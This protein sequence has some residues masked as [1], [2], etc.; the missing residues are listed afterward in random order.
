MGLQTR[1]S[2]EVPEP[3]MGLWDSELEETSPAHLLANKNSAFLRL[4]LMRRAR[5][6]VA[7]LQVSNL[8]SRLHREVN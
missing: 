4:A 6:D 1:S 5:R 3:G 8:L 2:L 7:H